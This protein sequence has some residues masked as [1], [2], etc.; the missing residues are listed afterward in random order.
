MPAPAANPILLLG[1]PR[2]RQRSHP[3]VDRYDPL[4]LAGAARLRQTLLAFRQHHGFGRAIAAPQLGIPQRLIALQLPGWPEII[5]NPHITWRSQETLTLW[6][7]CMCFPW[8]LVKV[9][10]AVSISVQFSDLQGRLFYRSR[11]ETSVA[12]LLQH[13]ID[14]LDGILAVDR[15]LDQR[16][17]ISREAF[18]ANREY[19]SAQVDIPPPV[20]AKL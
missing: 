6:D 4:I 20:A 19:F 17:L 7:D 10:R 12:E 14:H 18:A 9:R 13:E 15:A 5:V 11:C 16:S 8:L 1:E 3:L 2:L